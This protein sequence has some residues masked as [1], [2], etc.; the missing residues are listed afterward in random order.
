MPSIVPVAMNRATCC[1][2]SAAA[3]ASS[4]DCSIATPPAALPRLKPTGRSKLR[5]KSELRRQQLRHE[6]EPRETQRHAPPGC[7]HAEERRP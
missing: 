1:V 6:C 7:R 2:S 3:A 5:A 4:G